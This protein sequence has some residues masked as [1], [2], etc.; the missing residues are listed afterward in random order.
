MHGRS[1]G[2][3]LACMEAILY[4]TAIIFPFFHRLLLCPSSNQ[5]PPP[6]PSEYRVPDPIVLTYDISP[7]NRNTKMQEIPPFVHFC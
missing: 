4:F 2:Y 1:P 7:V 6:H 3:W 5:S